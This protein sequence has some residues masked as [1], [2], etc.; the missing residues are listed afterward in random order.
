M[1]QPTEQDVEIAQAM[2]EV[3]A[4][5]ERE[6]AE[7]C[8]RYESIVALA[9]QTGRTQPGRY[10]ALADAMNASAGITAIELWL[11]RTC[12][13]LRDGRLE[14]PEGWDCPEPARC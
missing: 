13:G 6:G 11:G 2:R 10:E 3:Y 14:L 1:K 12:A 7:A 9:G 4:D 5:L 8:A